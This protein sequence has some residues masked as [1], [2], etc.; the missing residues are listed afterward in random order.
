M[1]RNVCDSPVRI[2]QLGKS[3]GCTNVTFSPTELEPGNAGILDIEL[4]STGKQGAM[5]SAVS[6]LGDGDKDRVVLLRIEV[7]A[8]VSNAAVLR[9]QPSRVDFGSI[10]VSTGERRTVDLLSS[11]P[12]G[13]TPVIVEDDHIVSALGTEVTIGTPTPAYGVQGDT[14]QRRAVSVMLPPTLPAGLFV[15]HIQ[16][17]GTF[18]GLARRVTITVVARVQSTI[19][20]EPASL[21]FD[22]IEVGQAAQ[23]RVV[24]HTPTVSNPSDISVV[25]CES[26]LSC[27]LDQYD[28]GT[29][30]AEIYLRAV[31]QRKGIAKGSATV[32]I[33]RTELSIPVTLYAR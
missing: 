31:A 5:V 1:V 27:I 33:G 17:Q 9:A 30:S 7:T 18:R 23:A 15:D 24:I 19:H 13:S 11:W 2:T 8:Y 26:W 4:D 16:I 14:L 21:F 12:D 25:C 20:A 3:C 28:P 29:R 10:D 22:G 32:A 6:L